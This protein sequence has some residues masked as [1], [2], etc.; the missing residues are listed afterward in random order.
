MIGRRTHRCL[1]FRRLANR[2]TGLRYPS[3]VNTANAERPRAINREYRT[4]ET[5]RQILNCSW[6]KD[7]C[8]NSTGHGPEN[9]TKP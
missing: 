7:L 5:T 8:R 3:L 4:I 9:T 2:R 6:D 1:Q